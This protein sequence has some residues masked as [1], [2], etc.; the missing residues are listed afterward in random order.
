MLSVGIK[1]LAGSGSPVGQYLDVL[2]EAVVAVFWQWLV[3]LPE[4]Q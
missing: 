3:L 2:G 4:S 1:S